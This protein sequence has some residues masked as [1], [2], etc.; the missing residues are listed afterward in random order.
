VVLKPSRMFQMSTSDPFDDTQYLHGCFHPESDAA[1]II[2]THVCTMMHDD[3]ADDDVELV[4]RSDDDQ[5]RL[6]NLTVG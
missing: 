5:L 4:W 6:S 1:A 3:T 2:N